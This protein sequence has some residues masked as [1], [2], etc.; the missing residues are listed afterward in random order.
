MSSETSPRIRPD[1]TSRI[2]KQLLLEFTEEVDV[3]EYGTVLQ[4]GDGIARVHGLR[5]VMLGELVSFPNDASGMA[6]NLEEEAVGCVLFGEEGLIKEGDAARRTGRIAEVPVGEALMGRIIDPLGRPLDAMGEL[7]TDRRMPIERRAP[8]IVDRQLVHEPLYTG[9]KAVDS[10]T[11]IG[12]G[13]RQL[14]IGDRQTGKTAIAVDTILNQRGGDVFCIYVAIG[15]ESSTVAKVVKTL[16][17]YGAREYTVVV[18]ASA[19]EAAALQFLAPYAGTTVGEYFRD[20]GRHALIVYD[21]LSKHAWAYRQVSLLLRRPPGRE[22]YPGD[23]FYVHSRLLERA[24]KLND[25]RGGGS[26]TALPIVET[27]EGDYSTYIP[28]NLISITDGQIF[29]SPDLFHAGVRPAINPGISVSRVAGDAQIPAMRRVS[30]SLRL[31]L[32]RYREVAAFAQF[33]A[34]L[35]RATQAQLARGER[36]VEILK[37]DQYEPM[38]VEK[39]IVSLLAATAGY[40][41]TLPISQ[42]RH[43]EHQLQEFFQE[44]HSTLLTEIAETRAIDEDL[45]LRLRS[46]IE[47]F[48]ELIYVPDLIKRGYKI[49]PAIDLSLLEKIVVQEAMSTEYDAIQRDTEFGAIVQSIQTGRFTDF[50]VVDSRGIF[51]G[52]IY[53]EDVRSVM[54]EDELYHLLVADDL[55]VEEAPRAR[56]KDTLASALTKLNARVAEFLPVVVEGEDRA[57]VGILTRF[58]LMRRYQQELIRRMQR[59]GGE[60]LQQGG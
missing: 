23:I 31:D 12:R 33:G 58:D 7:R 45:D 56:P 6:L 46:A 1:E 15:Q 28:T 18:S 49:E 38:P 3:Y 43:F 54:M 44:R 2:L 41:D 14:L 34:E 8:G 4:V 20:S 21:D 53:F 35:D 11:A 42:V 40:L 13:Q 29:L 19:S 9:L 39:E 16:E 22:A 50:P 5:N 10:M 36:L 59:P 37:Q 57:L 32:A 25:A 55:L 51:L 48:K 24:A 26:L 52:M 60:N 17:E 27:Y 47:E 30:G